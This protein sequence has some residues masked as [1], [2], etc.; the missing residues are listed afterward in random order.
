MFRPRY[1]KDN[2][3]FFEKIKNCKNEKEIVKLVNKA[4]HSNLVA[5]SKAIY[6]CVSGHCENVPEETIHLLKK[7]SSKR[8]VKQLK[9]YFGSRRKVQHLKKNPYLLIKSLEK[10]RSLIPALTLFLW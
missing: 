4:K 8:I 6:H 3:Q 10:I 5:L 9:K 2:L 7:E 1:I